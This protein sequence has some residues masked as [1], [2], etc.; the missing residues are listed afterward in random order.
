MEI[1]LLYKSLDKLF[2][3]LLKKRIDL[4][5]TLSIDEGATKII[6]E[7]IFKKLRFKKQRSEHSSI[8]Q[9]VC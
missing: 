1:E 2:D 3:Q 4:D 9:Q 7:P 5:Y 6:E 8:Y